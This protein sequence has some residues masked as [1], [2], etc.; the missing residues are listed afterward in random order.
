MRTDN[1]EYRKL[2]FESG[3]D[4]RRAQLARV[5][6]RLLFHGQ[7][8]DYPNSPHAMDCEPWS[9]DGTGIGLIPYGDLLRETT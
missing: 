3:Q 9:G 6:K 4:C 8:P 2:L 1:V 7:I 5:H